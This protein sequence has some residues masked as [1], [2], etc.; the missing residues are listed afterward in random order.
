MRVSSA[1]RAEQQAGPSLREAGS[2]PERDF[3]LDQVADIGFDRLVTGRVGAY[4]GHGVAVDP[5]PLVVPV[6]G[7]E[8]TANLGNREPVPVG[9]ALSVGEQ[10]AG[11]FRGSQDYRPSGGVRVRRNLGVNDPGDEQQGGEDRQ[12]DEQ[13]RERRKTPGGLSR[14]TPG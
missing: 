6:E 11:A 9:D 10:D 8:T 3:H 12:P 13:Q 14:P 4:V 2:V 7:D 5:D 1:I